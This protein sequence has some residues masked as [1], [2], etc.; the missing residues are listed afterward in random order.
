MARDLR[1]AVVVVRDS[2]Y[3]RYRYLEHP[4]RQ[5]TVLA[6]R[7]LATFRDL[8]VL[9]LYKEADTIEL[10][11]VIAP[12]KHIPFLVDQARAL[13]Y[14][15]GKRYIYCWIT[16]QNIPLFAASRQS[17]VNDLDIEIPTNVWVPQKYSPE[18][19][20][21]RWWLTSGDTDFH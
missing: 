17:E 15:W 2:A 18:Q 19:L 14:E 10:V 12:L 7:S 1:P 5:Y 16:R 21:D 11:D 20:K 6:I 8:G 13:A 9:V 3:V 4:T